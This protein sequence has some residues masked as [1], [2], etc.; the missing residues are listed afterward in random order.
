MK[1]REHVIAQ[2]QENSARAN[3]SFIE[4]ASFAATLVQL[5]YDTDNATVM[6]ALGVDR[7][8]LSKM[9][10]V[11]GIPEQILQAIGAAKAVGRDRW[12]ELKL[13]LEK[14]S[15]YEVALRTVAEDDFSK[16]SSE[17]RFLLL[18]ARLKAAKKAPR[19]RSGQ[20]KRVWIP[21][22][23][24]LSAEMAS[25]GKNFILA[26]KAKSDEA[27]MFGGYLSENLDRIYE[28][29]KQESA[30]NRNGD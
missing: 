8:T 9:L 20:P 14:P 2:G 24:S 7:T 10:S 12:Y 18:L 22:D 30:S 27:T 23:G 1:D 6:A 21:D 25:V 29:F 5:R 3:L 28:A 13:L 4:K 15:S 16:L 19:S 26:L 11:A 17:E